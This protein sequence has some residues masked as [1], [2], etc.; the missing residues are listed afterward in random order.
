VKE[1]SGGGVA[2]RPVSGPT[3]PATAGERASLD[4]GARLGPF[5]IIDRLGA[6]GMGEVYRALD[7]RLGR[8]VA[9]KVLPTDLLSNREGLARFA[10][11]A[12]S[13][14]ALNHPNIVTIFEIGH[15]VVKTSDPAPE[16]S[17]HFISM[18]LVTG[19]TLTR[20]IHVEK[21]D[22]RTLVGYI[23]QAAEGIAR[24][25]AAGI[26]HRD[27]KPENILMQEGQPLIADFGIALAVSN[28]GGS[29]VTQT[30]V[31]LG[32]PQYMSPEQAM[33]DRTLDGRSDI[34]SLGA[35]TYEMLVGDPPHWAS[36]SQAVLAKVL[37]ERPAAVRTNRPS[38]PPYVDAAVARALEKLP[39]DRF[40]SAREFADALAGK[41]ATA[42]PAPVAL[43][44]PRARAG[45]IAPRE[46]AAWTLVLGLAG[47]AGW[48][49]LNREAPPAPH[50]VR[51]NLDL[52][53][54]L[55]VADVLSGNTIA[56]SP[57]SDAIA[58]TSV[59]SGGYTLY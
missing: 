6:G 11:E 24:A 56:V 19:E 37:T 58:F 3:E 18:E 33:A 32:T 28:A 22:L 30:G 42:S 4:L 2:V 41:V 40:A 51:V 10:L 31:S 36:T 7:S 44:E 16:A 49:A 12:R 34:Y 59:R 17:V 50:V 55:R 46:I 45:R 8:K 9:L 35:M 29:R 14:S 57:A 26:V 27:L 23:A 52:P 38:T 53:A 13:A 20:R 5:Q 47:V 25:H 15:D 43:M 1:D 39:A 48:T 54:G 21:D